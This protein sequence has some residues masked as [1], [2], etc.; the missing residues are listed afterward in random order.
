MGSWPLCAVVSR[1]SLSINYSV[2]EHDWISEIS[3]AQDAYDKL[4]VERSISIIDI[5]IPGS[6]APP[7]GHN[8]SGFTCMAKQPSPPP[9][10]KE[11]TG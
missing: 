9:R 7:S 4:L 8:Q 3:D 10:G 1:E 6:M 2:K 5:H 11:I